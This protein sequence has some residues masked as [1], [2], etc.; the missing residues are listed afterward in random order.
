M[1]KETFVQLFI[2]QRKIV[3]VVFHIYF[4]FKSCS[5]PKYLQKI[6]EI[7]RIS[8]NIIMEILFCLMKI[9]HKLKTVCISNK[10]KAN[11]H[12]KKPKYKL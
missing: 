6:I 4:L 3:S 2:A 5:C 12:I 1:C 7:K 9:M 8:I 10:I 11:R